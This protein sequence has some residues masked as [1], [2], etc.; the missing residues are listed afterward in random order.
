MAVRYP[1]GGHAPTSKTVLGHLLLRDA[2]RDTPLLYP[3]AQ[4][5]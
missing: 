2:N 3:G 5:S 4:L 1:A